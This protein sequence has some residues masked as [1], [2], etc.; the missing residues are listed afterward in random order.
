MFLNVPSRNRLAVVCCAVVCAQ[1]WIAT[2]S[3][4]SAAVNAVDSDMK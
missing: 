4:F 1:L 3:V 2:A